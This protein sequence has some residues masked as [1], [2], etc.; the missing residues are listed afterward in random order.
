MSI[1][2]D[3]VS[4]SLKLMCSTA[5][6]VFGSAI[7]NLSPD[8]R[9]RRLLKVKERQSSPSSSGSSS[10]MALRAGKLGIASASVASAKLSAAAERAALRRNASGPR[11]Q[12]NGAPASSSGT[13]RKTGTATHSP[14]ASEASSSQSGSTAY[15]SVASSMSASKQ[16]NG[17][18]SLAGPP[19]PSACFEV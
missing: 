6:F 19:Q 12:A 9:L 4:S 17:S 10:S 3:A 13:Q 11:W 5:V 7:N 16:M 14:P 18:G 8:V 2:C 1:P 15:Y